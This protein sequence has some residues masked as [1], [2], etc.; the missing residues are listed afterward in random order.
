ML[1]TYWDCLYDNIQFDINIK[2][3]QGDVLYNKS[4]VL[5]K[6]HWFKDYIGNLFQ[7]NDLLILNKEVKSLDISFIDNVIIN[8]EY[9]EKY[10][11]LKKYE[12]V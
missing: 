3:V 5:N 9:L 7:N 2:N 1:Y 8:K 11:L 10:A 4:I 6:G 12:K